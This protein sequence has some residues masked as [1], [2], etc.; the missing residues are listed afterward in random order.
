MIPTDGALLRNHWIVIDTNSPLVKS[1][2][3]HSPKHLQHRLFSHCLYIILETSSLHLMLF[4]TLILHLQ[5]VTILW[6][7]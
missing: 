7:L 6:H 3:V 2:P 4:C 5:H 1:S